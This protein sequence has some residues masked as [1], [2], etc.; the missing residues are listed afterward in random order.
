MTA[1]PIIQ[2]YPPADG[3]DWS[4]SCARCGGECKTWDCEECDDGFVEE[5]WGDDVVAEIHDVPCETCDGHGFWWYCA[6]TPEWCEAN[7]L[8]GREGV[9]RGKIEWTEGET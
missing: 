5:D 4:P 6:N 8:P 3:R 2:A 7:P 9:E 1:Q